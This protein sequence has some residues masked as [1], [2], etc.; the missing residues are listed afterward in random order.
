MRMTRNVI[1]RLAQQT[2]CSCGD[3][4][5]WHDRCYAG[6]SNPKIRAEMVVA[7]KKAAAELKRRYEESANAVIVLAAMQQ[8]IK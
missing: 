5:T 2:P 1:D 4:D 3:I 7:Y 6:K 8:H